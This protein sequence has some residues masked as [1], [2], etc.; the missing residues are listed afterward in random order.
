MRY[1]LLLVSIGVLVISA[2]AYNGFEDMVP[3]GDVHSC[4]TCHYSG[5]F[6]ED[7]HA[8]GD[9]WT[10]ALASLDSDGDGA[11]NGEELGDPGGTWSVGKP[12]PG[13]PF[14]VTNPDDAEDNP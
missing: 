1:I 6:R 12:S 13:D 4:N 8:A 14:V 5:A 11:T 9:R 10:T 2:T 7:F 3:N